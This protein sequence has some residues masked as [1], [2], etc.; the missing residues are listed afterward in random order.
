M[1]KKPSEYA[2]NG[3]NLKDIPD[4]S[5]LINHAKMQSTKLMKGLNLDDSIWNYKSMTGYA[6]PKSDFIFDAGSWFEPGVSVGIS[7]HV[8]S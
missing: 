7:T 1:L 5:L 6:K 3:S 8:L 4:G 2:L